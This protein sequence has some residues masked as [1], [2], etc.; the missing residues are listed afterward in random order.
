MELRDGDLLLREPTL[1]DVE[2]VAASVVAS[3]PELQPWMP[4]ADAGYTPEDSRKWIAGE[5]GDA[6]R[7]ILLDADGNHLGNCGLNQL[8]THNRTANLGYWLHS[9]HTGRGY[10]TRATRLLA[11]YGTRDAGL[12]RI[13]VVMSVANEPSRKVAERAGAHYEGRLRNCMMLDGESHDAHLW[14]FIP[15][16]FD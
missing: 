13:E 4:W 2:T 7:F 11:R 5:L 10:A 14:S 16:D 6:H 3:M 9:D 8:N 1:D 15:G 12:M